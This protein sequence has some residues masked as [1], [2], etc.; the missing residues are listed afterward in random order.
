MKFL[1]FPPLIAALLAD[2][3][4][5]VR[6]V[7]GVVGTVQLAG[8]LETVVAHFAHRRF[9][10]GLRRVEAL[11]ARFLAGRLTRRVRTG[12]PVERAAAAAASVSAPV[13]VLPRG[14]GWLVA[15][16]GYQAAGCGSQLEALLARPEM[17]ALL[18][19]SPAA[20][21]ALR[22]MCRALGIAGSVLRPGVVEVV[23]EPKVRAPRV[24]TKRA[25]VDW[26]RVPL[27]RG[28][29]AA[30]RRQGFGKRV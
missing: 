27:P 22:P 9:Q 7:Q 20:G 30:A 25:P 16:G 6:A 23:R 19:A 8:R 13:L 12:G 3:A 21:R 29:L 10:Q 14:F 2:L 11:L 17:V 5:V 26:G 28:V 15:L 1:P 24:R 4:W 18:A